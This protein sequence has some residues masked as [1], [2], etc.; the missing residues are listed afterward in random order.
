MEK[1]DQETRAA[2]AAK[3]KSGNTTL[4]KADRTLVDAQLAQEA[5]IR[6]RVKDALA[7]VHQSFRTIRSLLTLSAED[8]DH[9]LP[10]IEFSLLSAL[11]SENSKLFEDE[12]FQTALVSIDAA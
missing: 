3:K 6:T 8:R 4:S 7:R 10:K 2:L 12:G 11:M 9:F 1:W 5:E